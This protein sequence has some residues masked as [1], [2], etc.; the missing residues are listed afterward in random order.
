LSIGDEIT[1]V[2]QIDVTTKQY[3]DIMHYLHKATEPVTFTVVK[4]AATF[5][6]TH[7]SR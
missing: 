1:M 5:G 2:D 7:K 4:H 3:D 6:K